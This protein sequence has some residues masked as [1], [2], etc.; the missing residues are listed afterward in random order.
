MKIYKITEA[1]AY[2]GISINSLKERSKMTEQQI[3]E[4]IK[5]SGLSIARGCDVCTDMNCKLCEENERDIINKCA[6]AI[7]AEI[8]PVEQLK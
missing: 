3:A 5:T 6:K 8:K 1:S 7:S 4:I 2:L